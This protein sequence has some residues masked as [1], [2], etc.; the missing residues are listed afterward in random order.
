MS[1]KAEALASARALKTT[2]DTIAAKDKAVVVAQAAQA[3]AEAKALADVAAA[4]AEAEV[5]L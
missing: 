5:A 4:R 2:I 1:E 3:A